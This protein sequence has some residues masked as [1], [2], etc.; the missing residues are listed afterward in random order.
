M[1]LSHRHFYKTSEEAKIAPTYKTFIDRESSP[2]NKNV[3]ICRDSRQITTT[4][5]KHTHRTA[6]QPGV[7][8][9]SLP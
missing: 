9:E 8:R 3:V 1:D 6:H 2:T 7:A 4:N 5:I